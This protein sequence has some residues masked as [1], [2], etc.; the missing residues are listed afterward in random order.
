MRPQ[1]AKTN[2]I[3][4]E[5]EKKLNNHFIKVFKRSTIGSIIPFYI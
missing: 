4:V 3:M 1:V 5:G 2:S